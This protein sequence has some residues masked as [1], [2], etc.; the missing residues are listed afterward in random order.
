[1]DWVRFSSICS[2]NSISFDCRNQS[3][4]I[5]GL[6]S[7]EFDWVRFPKVRLTMPGLCY[8]PDDV[9]AVEKIMVMP[10]SMLDV[11]WLLNGTFPYG[12][13][14]CDF[15][16]RWLNSLHEHCAYST[17]YTTQPTLLIDDQ[18]QDVVPLGNMQDSLKVR[19]VFFFCL[20][21]FFRGGG[22][23]CFCFAL[24]SLK[25]DWPGVTWSGV[26]E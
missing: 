23:N 20:S 11:D 1:M 25:I 3:N 7:I 19:L 6:S 2:I 13:F 22:G 10:S 12:T 17:F 4:S 16:Q 5:H 21:F 15:S 18:E 14:L 8:T 26:T 24:L 9:H